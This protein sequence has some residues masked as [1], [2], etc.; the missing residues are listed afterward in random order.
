MVKDIFLA[1]FALLVLS[2]CKV[3]DRQ[4]LQTDLLWKEWRTAEQHSYQ[5]QSETKPFGLGHKKKAGK[6]YPSIMQKQPGEIR[7]YRRI[8]RN[9]V[10]SVSASVSK[11]MRADAKLIV[12]S[13]FPDSLRREYRIRPGRRHLVH[14]NSFE[15]RIVRIT[16]ASRDGKLAWINPVLEQ[17]PDSVV[18]PPEGLEAFRK[19][20]RDDNVLIFLFDATNASHLSCYG[21]PKSTTPVMDSIAAEG[22]LWN[23]AIAQA[24]YTIASTGSLFT[25]LYPSAF[26]MKYDQG[27][28]Q[29]S[30]KT[31]AEAFHESG[32]ATAL[33]TANPNASPLFGYGQG[34]DVT[35]Q[36]YGN[37]KSAWETPVF[38]SEFVEPV[39]S[40][41][42]SVRH[43]RFF[44]YVHFREPHDP[45]RP[46]PEYIV[47]FGG[48]PGF[49]SHHENFEE[50]LQAPAEDRKKIIAAYDGGLNYVDEQLGKILNHLK[51]RNLDNNTITVILAD[52][53][54]AFWEHGNFDHYYTLY[55]EVIR[56]PLILRFPGE[57]NLKGIR[58]HE[59]VG[60]IDLFPTFSSL[61]GFSQKGLHFNGRS[62]LPLLSGGSGSRERFLLTRTDKQTYSLRSQ[63]FHLIDY[64]GDDPREDEL[65][66]L[67]KDPA[68]R[69]NL[70][71]G[72]PIVTSFYR[73]QIRK[74][75]KTISE[76]RSRMPVKERKAVIDK[77][78]EEQLRA[79]GYVNK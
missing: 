32:Y 10:L 2:G 48:D 54:E 63:M 38:A 31:M 71:K 77:Q 76:R 41:L 45:Y 79:L 74:Q 57:G 44:G 30:F 39:T 69:D 7:F 66:Y 37:R 3:P 4:S 24:S 18:E 43:R 20:H 53:G 75:L 1:L 12:E 78:T 49:R 14:L 36:L 27:V 23:N 61:F 19:R 56:I 58:K 34:F 9:A 46:P 55:N 50:L 68:E 22:V 28:L 70:A 52:H 6:S 40:W 25:G 65:F 35:N 60:S 8:G 59:V 11:A 73:E 47:R 29:D 62:L 15:Q 16:F 67:P 21:Y 17:T 33:F 42:D 5:Q 72:H 26:S 64:S 13:D 51:K